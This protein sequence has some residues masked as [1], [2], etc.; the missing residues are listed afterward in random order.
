MNTEEE[1]P[2]LPL[3]RYAFS[4]SDFDRLKQA[5]GRLQ[6]RCMAD[7][8]FTDFPLDPKNPSAGMA[9][10]VT[11]LVSSG[12]FGALDLALARRWGYGWDP[13]NRG[14]WEP[15]DRT[16]TQEEYEVLHGPGLGG[17][18]TVRGRK[19]PENGCHGA[20][21]EQ[22]DRGV[23]DSTRMWSYVSGRE[24]ELIKTEPKDD[25]IRRAW[26]T[27][28]R[29][30]EDRGFGQYDNPDKAFGDKTWGR[31]QGGNTT[32]TAREV[33]TAVADVECKRQYNTVGVWWAV[34]AERQ[35]ADIDRNRAAYE[36]IRG[37]LDVVRGNIARALGE[38]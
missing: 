16:M 19:V 35:R 11:V 23:K 34:R 5:Q 12:P 7:F 2:E 9:A 28:A 26:D 31:D 13:R 15:K 20:A 17:A 1:I 10:I 22:L 32:R 30:V 24:A 27:W 18:S 33:G 8:G 14:G 21:S 3:A 6:Q 4:D 29:C 37:D 36:A 25:R 38:G